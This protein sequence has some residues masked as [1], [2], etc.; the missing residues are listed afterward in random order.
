MPQTNPVDSKKCNTINFKYP[1]APRVFFSFI[2]VK[3]RNEGNDVVCFPN[4]KKQK[5]I[6]SIFYRKPMLPWVVCSKT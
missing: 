2:D 4:K 5:I 1:T 3:G 6:C